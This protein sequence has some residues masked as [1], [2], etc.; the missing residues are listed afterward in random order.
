MALLLAVSSTDAFAPLRPP[1]SLSRHS[2]VIADLSPTRLYEKSVDEEV[3]EMVKE[4]I[5]KSKMMS[6]L[7]NER[8]IEYA[9]WMGIDAKNP[10]EIRQIM[11]E[12]VEARR[13]RAQQEMDVSGSL[14]KDSAA[15]ELGGLGVRA[16]IIDQS[17]VE[18][19]WATDVESS[20]KGFKVKRRATKTSDFDVLASYENNALL[21]SKGKDGGTY[22]FLDE[23]ASP[24]GWVYRITE[25]E[26]NGNENDLSQ[27]LVEIQ[28]EEEQRG[29]K[30]AAAAFGIIA[31]LT[32]IAASVLD[33]LQ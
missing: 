25:C 33:P 3:E 1:T 28:T 22:R 24:G 8:G 20:T 31:V 9:P 5:E 7:S 29:A 6:K 23:T 17:T 19:E 13:R 32:V 2:S 27:C 4:S 12:K 14:L 11:R 16:K 21:V 26:S 18:L 30:I 10:E 15:A